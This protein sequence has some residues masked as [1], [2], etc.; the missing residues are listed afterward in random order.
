MP[1]SKHKAYIIG[2]GSGT[3]DYL[4]PRAEKIISRCGVVTGWQS[5]LE[6]ASSLIKGKKVFKQDGG[7]YMDVLR[8]AGKNARELDTDIAVLLLGDPMTYPAGINI[9]CQQF[10]DFD[11][12]FIPAVG[13]LQLAAA[14]AMVSIEDCRIILYHPD[15]LGNMDKADLG[16]KRETMLKAIKEGYNLIIL[17]DMEQMPSQTAKFLVQNDV[18]PQSEVVIS[19]RP[20]L[21][22]EKITRLSLSQAAEYNANWMSVMVVKAR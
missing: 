6:A 13:S 9:F 16:R 20:G 7:N 11:V 5:G 8:Q 17:S 21:A 1:G 15:S 12:E 19:E 4:T 10:T 3:N 14:A 22:G 18:A 2:V